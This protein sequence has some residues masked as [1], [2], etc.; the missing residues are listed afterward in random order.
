MRRIMIGFAALCAVL[1][2]GAILVPQGEVVT[3]HVLD[4]EGHSHP[5]QLWIVE[6]DGL[7]YLRAASPEVRWLERLRTHPDVMLGGGHG[8][9][10]A[11]LRAT[12]LDADADARQ[13]VA[14]AMAEKYGLADRLWAMLGDRA[15]SVPIRLEPLSGPGSESAHARSTP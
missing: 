3:L 7:R 14:R 8:D 4:D 5:T 9:E 12:P 10:R 6:L 2:V 15:Q 13:R 11:P 1:A